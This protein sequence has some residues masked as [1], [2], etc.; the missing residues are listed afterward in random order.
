MADALPEGIDRASAA[1]KVKWIVPKWDWV[2]PL[3]ERQAEALAVEKGFK[4]RSDVIEAEGYDPEEMDQ[5]IANDKEREERLGLNFA[6]ATKGADEDDNQPDVD[7]DEEEEGDEAD[8]IP[9][10]VRRL[11]P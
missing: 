1:G 3:K 11:L 9:D 7:E 2:D 8:T 6:P 4:S 5:R 10:N